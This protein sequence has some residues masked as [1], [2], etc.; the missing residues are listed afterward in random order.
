MLMS[1]KARSPAGSTKVQARHGLAGMIMLLPP[2]PIL[3]TL[4]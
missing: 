2:R 3:Q 4:P 1:M